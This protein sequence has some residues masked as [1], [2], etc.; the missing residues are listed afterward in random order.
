[1]P[2]V[3]L[4]AFPPYIDEVNTPFEEGIESLVRIFFEGLP[5]PPNAGYQISTKLLNGI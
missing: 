4:R 2:E 3:S 5:V 1:M